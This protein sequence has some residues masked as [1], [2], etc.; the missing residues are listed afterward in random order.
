MLHYREL[1][2]LVQEKAQKQL[3]ENDAHKSQTNTSSMKNEKSKDD[4][5]KY[6]IE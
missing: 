1:E 3:V 4:H 6:V 5:G 2:L